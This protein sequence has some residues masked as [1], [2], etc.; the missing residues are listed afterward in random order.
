MS[1]RIELGVALLAGG[2]VFVDAA[3]RQAQEEALAAAEAAIAE[4]RQCQAL[5][6]A[7]PKPTTETPTR[8]VLGLLGGR[9]SGWF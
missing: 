4:E 5:E 9:A 6:E 7:Q 2:G 8:T 1:N 3:V